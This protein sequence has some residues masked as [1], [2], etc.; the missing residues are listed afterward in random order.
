MRNRGFWRELMEQR[1]I[2][3][4]HSTRGI[5]GGYA[6]RTST[7]ATPCANVLCGASSQEE[8]P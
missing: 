3:T 2:N 5:T 8:V 6:V 1:V 7:F 4:R